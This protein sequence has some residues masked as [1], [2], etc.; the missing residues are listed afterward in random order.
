M[1]TFRTRGRRW[2]VVAIAVALVTSLATVLL[3]PWLERAVRGRIETDR[4]YDIKIELAGNRIRCYLDG[5]LI[6]DA[7]ATPPESFA[8]GESRR[9]SPPTRRKHRPIR[10]LHDRVKPQMIGQCCS[11]NPSRSRTVN[12]NRVSMLSFC[13]T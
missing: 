6:H 2:L 12:G 3:R 10:S 1:S 7:T 8:T 11:A 4:W 5:E 13:G 9:C